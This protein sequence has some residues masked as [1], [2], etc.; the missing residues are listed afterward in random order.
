MFFP[1]VEHCDCASCVPLVHQ[2][3]LLRVRR[4]DG[5]VWDV[6]PAAPVHPPAEVPGHGLPPAALRDAHRAAGQPLHRV[7]SPW[8]HGRRGHQTQLLGWRVQGHRSHVQPSY[9]KS[10]AQWGPV[11]HCELLC[12]RKAPVYWLLKWSILD[13]L[14]L[15]SVQNK[16][17]HNV[18]K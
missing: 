4:A 15:H 16:S 11:V 10:A 7:P 2:G 13:I 8:R 9:A 14:L 18:F 12:R 3:R 5:A 1:P 6:V 17:K